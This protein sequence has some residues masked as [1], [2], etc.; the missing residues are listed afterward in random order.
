MC[1]ISPPSSRLGCR[2][3]SRTEPPHCGES[4]RTTGAARALARNALR[5]VTVCLSYYESLCCAF[6]RLRCLLIAPDWN[7]ERAETAILVAALTTCSDY[8]YC[9]PPGPHVS[10]GLDQF[11]TGTKA[12]LSDVLLLK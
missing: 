12:M 1:L 6:L 10:P 11:S 2:W 9:R 4:A 5:L 7:G 8:S 3:I